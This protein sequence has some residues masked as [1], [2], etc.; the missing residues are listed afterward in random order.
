MRVIKSIIDQHN[1]T[2]DFFEEEK[3]VIELN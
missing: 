1:Q 2:G 3:R